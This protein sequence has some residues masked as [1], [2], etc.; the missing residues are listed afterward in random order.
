MAALYKQTVVHNLSQGLGWPQ[1]GMTAFLFLRITPPTFDNTGPITC[2]KCAL[3]NFRTQQGFGGSDSNVATERRASAPRCH[4][5]HRQGFETANYFARGTRLGGAEGKRGLPTIHHFFSLHGFQDQII[6]TQLWVCVPQ[7][8]PS[9]GGGRWFFVRER[10]G[11][12]RPQP[13]SRTLRGG[14]DLPR[15]R[16]AAGARRAPA[17]ADFRPAAGPRALGRAAGGREQ[18]QGAKL[19]ATS[20]GRR[21][22][23]ARGKRAPSACCR[24]A[25]GARRGGDLL[26]ARILLTW[27]SGPPRERGRPGPARYVQTRT[28]D[29]DRRSSSPPAHRYQPSLFS[30]A[31]GSGAVS[32]PYEF[33]DPPGGK[34]R[35]GIQFCRLLERTPCW[36]AL[37]THLLLC[38]DTRERLRRRVVLLAVV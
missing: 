19:R 34:W 31:S 18:R 25:A 28:I 6:K 5:T 9:A 22:R 21:P 35:R 17:A 8:Q 23:R 20:A 29:F 33:R 38:W 4:H 13:V 11:S 2:Q 12:R 37:G 27:G 26:T 15:A 3:R 32:F 36:K 1:E 7:P 14:A 24:G 16:P 10:L 30:L